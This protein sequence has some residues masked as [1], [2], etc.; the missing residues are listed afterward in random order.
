M[1]LM[2]NSPIYR[3][4]VG[5][6]QTV[7]SANTS[8]TESGWGGYTIV[9]VMAAANHTYSGLGSKIRVTLDVPASGNGQYGPVYVGHAAARGDT[10]DFDGNQVKLTFSAAD[11]ITPSAGSVLITDEV[12]FSFDGSKNVVCRFT[13]TGGTL[14]HVNP[15]PTGVSGYYNNSTASVGTTDVPFWTAYGARTYI[16]KIEVF[17]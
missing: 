11:T 7:F 17:A 12:N 5:T 6:W 4:S 13:G 9:N 15:G 1:L 2:P 3:P 10:Y 14:S 8:G 16:K